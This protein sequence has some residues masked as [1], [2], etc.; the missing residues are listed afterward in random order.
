M[1][2]C[3][4][5]QH[6]PD[7]TRPQWNDLKEVKQAQ[8]FNLL[9]WVFGDLNLPT[10]QSN[11]LILSG[12]A[13]TVGWIAKTFEIQWY[14]IFWY[15]IDDFV[16]TL[17]FLLAAPAGQFF[18]FAH[19]HIIRNTEIPASITTVM[20]FRRMA[21]EMGVWFI[22]PLLGQT[23]ISHHIFARLAWNVIHICGFKMMY[24]TFPL[25]Q[26]AS[27]MFLYLFGEILQQVLNG[28]LVYPPKFRTMS[29]IGSK[30]TW[31]STLFNDQI[32]ADSDSVV[33]RVG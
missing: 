22:S 1:Q 13:T 25:A 23:E 16:Y 18:S 12:I 20:L 17:T 33:F 15:K 19:W 11:T 24:P 30:L 5:G 27:W 26:Q 3:L 29:L 6:N 32:L 9:R 8:L 31:S 28:L 10:N 7:T 14:K 2:Q 21:Q 4:K